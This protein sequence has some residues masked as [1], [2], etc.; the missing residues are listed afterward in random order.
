MQLPH[1]F[2]IPKLP[3]PTESLASQTD[4]DKWTHLQGITL[5]TLDH[6][7]ITL[8]IG[9]DNPS[10]LVPIDVRKGKDNEPYAT[11]TVFGWTL[12]GRLEYGS[13]RRIVSNF[14]QAE[15]SLE[16][17]VERFWKLD[18]CEH[19]FDSKPQMSVNDK[20]VIDIWQESLEVEEGHYKMRIPFRSELPSMPNNYSVAEVR[21]EYL[22]RK[23][24]KNKSLHERY[25]DGIQEL[26]SKGYAEKVPHEE[27]N[28]KEGPVWYIPHH[29]M[30]SEKKPDK[31]RIVFD[32]AASYGGT[33]LNEE[34]LQGPDLTNTLI[35][36]LLRFRQE[37]IAIMGDIEAMFHQVRVA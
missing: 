31:L 28:P 3:V 12:N 24:S 19:I 1:V 14:V 35:G 11:R 33:S 37:K 8:L 15:H 30:I 25:R 5:P 22:G 32:C 4:V 17:S 6:G 29:A 36:V 21:L 18:S 20:R 27:T 23:L 9:Q 34:V 16:S 2:V 26:L 13:Q 10:A 7:R